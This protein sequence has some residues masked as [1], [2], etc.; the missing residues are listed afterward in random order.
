MASWGDGTSEGA[1][2]TATDG[3]RFV[4]PRVT[5]LPLIDCLAV[6]VAYGPLNPA[7]PALPRHRQRDEIML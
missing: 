6:V 5:H 7:L 3:Y 4:G 2:A 1:L